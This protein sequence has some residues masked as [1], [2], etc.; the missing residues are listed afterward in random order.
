MP[1]LITHFTAAYLL[2][3]PRRWA[4]FRVPFYLGA[5]LPDLLTR[6]LYILFPPSIYVVYSLHTPI[7]TAVVCLLIAM[8]F[9]EEIR[10]G[11]RRNLLLGISLHYGLDIMQKYFFSG[12][13]LFYP[14]SS[15]SLGLQLFWSE[16]AL[17]LVPV[18]VIIVVGIEAFCL[19]KRRVKRTQ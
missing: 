6:P 8:F 13:L 14:F 1:D 17:Q 2:K 9:D 7:V 4:R 11:V 12:Y 3:L 18:W 19:V 15:K 10:S 5:I 16:E